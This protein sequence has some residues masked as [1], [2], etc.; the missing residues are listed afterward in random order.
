M[1]W[2]FWRR[3]SHDNDAVLEELLSWE[4]DNYIRGFRSWI[5][6]PPPRNTRVEVTR[7]EWPVLHV[8]DVDSVDPTTNIAGLWWR[9]A[10]NTEIAAA[11]RSSQFLPDKWADRASP[12]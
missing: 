6:T 11:S 8:W 5:G 2:Q 1:N 7:Q 10:R 3:S 12:I 4:A 9:E